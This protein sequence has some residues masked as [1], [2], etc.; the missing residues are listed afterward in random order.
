MLSL[1]S[2]LSKFECETCNLGGNCNSGLVIKMPVVEPMSNVML[3]PITPH[4]YS[5]IE[6]Y[7]VCYL[8]TKLMCP[9]HDSPVPLF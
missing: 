3:H 5:V 2:V 9:G 6:A 8:L 4:F 7:H 1:I